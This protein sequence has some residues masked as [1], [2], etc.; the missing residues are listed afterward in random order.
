MQFKYSTHSIGSPVDFSVGVSRTDLMTQWNRCRFE[1]ASLTG[2]YSQAWEGT[3]NVLLSWKQEVS[4]GDISHIITLRIPETAQ[5]I[6]SLEKLR[7]RLFCHYLINL[8]S[9]EGLPELCESLSEM[10]QFYSTPNKNVAP[11]LP[12]AEGIRVKSGEKYERPTFQLAQE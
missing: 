10:F 1:P 7:Y 2:T 12:P 5:D 3:P 9:D 6:A 11:A 8:I 4:G